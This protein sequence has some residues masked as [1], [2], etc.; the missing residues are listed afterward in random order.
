MGREGGRVKRLGHCPRPDARRPAGRPAAG[1]SGACAKLMQRRGLGLLEARAK[2]AD[3]VDGDS[4][5]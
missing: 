1:L 2:R 4:E 5:Q 3:T